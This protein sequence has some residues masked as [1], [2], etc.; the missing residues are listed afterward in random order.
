MMTEGLRDNYG[1]IFGDD[2]TSNGEEKKVEDRIEGEMPDRTM[3]FSELEN[4]EMMKSQADEI[5]GMKEVTDEIDAVSMGGRTE[6]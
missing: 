4:I 2:G 1:R 6:R 5:P 3:E